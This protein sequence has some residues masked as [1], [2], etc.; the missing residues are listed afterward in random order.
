MPF[1]MAKTRQKLIKTFVL[2]GAAIFVLS[3][4]ALA[5]TITL[6]GSLKGAAGY[7]IA[8]LNK[9]GSSK[10]KLLSEK[11]AFSFS[12]VKLGKLKNASLQLIGVDGRFYGPVVLG[13]KGSKAAINFS[14][15]NPG[16]AKVLN[17]GK[18]TLKDGFAI[19][20]AAL[21]KAV[22]VAPKVLADRTGKPVGAG[23]SGIVSSTMVRE[24]SLL[25]ADSP[26]P[27]EDTDRDGIVNSLDADDNGNGILDAADPESE[28]TDTPYVGLNFDFRG[29]LNANVRDGLSSD[30][31]DELV[32]GENHFASTFFISLPQDSEI[33]G[34]YLVCGEALDYC[35]PNTP[36]GYSGG[37]SES[38]EAYRGPLSSL[39]NDAGYPILERISVGGNPAIVLSMQPRVGRGVFRAGDLYRVVLTSGSAEVSSRTFSLPPF[40]I[41]VPALKDYT[42]NGVTTTVDYGSVNSESGSIPGISSGNPIVLGSDGLLS[43]NFWRPQ[44]EPIGTEEDYQDFG[45]LSYGVIIENAQATCAGYFTEVS[46]ELQED[47]S[48]LGPGDSPFAHQGANLNPLVDQ[49]TDRPAAASNLLSFTVD[50]KSCIARAGVSPGTYSVVLSAA[51]P[52]LTG[53]R[54]A[55]NQNIYVTIP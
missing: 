45:G 43:V 54:N 1:L 2:L 53:G 40:F 37:V 30:L 22:Y 55:A 17:L 46:A 24:V 16:G 42:T 49:T 8:L 3:E 13:K 36:L 51:G 44:R 26:A 41:S 6:K 7:T 39:L 35:R 34:G 19:A 52:D 15:K 14:G 47:S 48:P 11:G 18:V 25:A 23:N 33:D 28:G 20:P 31:I 21:N 9:D 4:V 27:G 38:S 5:Q 12:G 50:L 29:T 10:T 32:S